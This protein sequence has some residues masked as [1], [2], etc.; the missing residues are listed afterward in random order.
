MSK[1]KPTDGSLYTKTKK[2]IYD[3]NPVHSAYRSG[4]LVKEYKRRFKMKHGAM[5]EPYTG[6]IQNKGLT[7]WFKE[8]WKNQRGGVGYKYKSD[9]YRPTKVITNKTP[10]T[11]KELSKSDISKAMKKKKLKGRVN[12]F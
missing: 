10:K 7:R 9:I 12:K 2:F 5:K 11:F 4:T 8:D 3:K 6:A 1:P